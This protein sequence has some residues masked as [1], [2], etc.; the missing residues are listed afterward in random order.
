MSSQK[1]YFPLKKLVKGFTFLQILLMSG[2]VGGQLAFAA[3]Q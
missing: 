1:V 2:L 3:S